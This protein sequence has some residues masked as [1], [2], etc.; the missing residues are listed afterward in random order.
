VH[1]CEA[2]VGSMSP[3][4]GCSLMSEQDFTSINGFI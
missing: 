3:Q 2:R 1:K 4:P